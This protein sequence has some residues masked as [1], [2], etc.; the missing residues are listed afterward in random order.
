MPATSR[1]RPDEAPDQRV[2]AGPVP[3]RFL[4]RID[5]VIV[6]TPSTPRTWRPSSTCSWPTAT[7]AGR[8][9][10]R[11]RADSGGEIADRD[12]RTDPAYGARPLKR[13]IQRLSRTRWRGR[14]SRRVQARGHDPGR[15]RRDRRHAGLRG[16]ARRFWPTRASAA[17]PARERL[18]S[19]SAS[20][21]RRRRPH[22]DARQEDNPK[23][24]N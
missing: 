2:A 18:P 15:R 9:G 21:P 22:L 6:F 19:R 3:A 7:A 8:T 5:E 14:C 1:L 20:P 10:D 16:P 11:S 13:T 23:R 4:N 24:V 17:T 12:R